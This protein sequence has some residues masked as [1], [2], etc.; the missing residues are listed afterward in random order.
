MY[1][2]ET[3]VNRENILF[4][5]EQKISLKNYDVNSFNYSMLSEH[6]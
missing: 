3:R 1:R 2:S 6:L 4:S 5:R